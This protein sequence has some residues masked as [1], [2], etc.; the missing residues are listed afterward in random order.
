MENGGFFVYT[1][2][3]YLIAGGDSR[4]ARLASLLAQSARVCAAGFSEYPGD[5]GKA[6]RLCALS[7]L[8]ES[9]DCLILP[10]PASRDG[11]TAAAPFSEETLPLSQLLDLCRRDTLVLAGMAGEG[12]ERLCAK[13]GLT[14]MDYA[15]REELAVLNAVPTAEG[16]LQIALEKLPTVLNGMDVLV[17]GYGRV[18][19]LCRRVFA[20]VGC[21][22]TAAARSR[23]ALAWAEAD[24][25]EPLPLHRM[26]EQLSRFRLVLN[27]VPH[28]LFGKEEL[29]R[30]PPGALLIDLASLPGGT[31]FDAAKELGVQ[32]VHALSLPGKS[33]PE[34]AADILCRTI[35]AIEAERRE[36]D[37]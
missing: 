28:L 13:R 10:M 16:A 19:K 31:D 23:E 11:L 14:L 25:A 29:S 6:E 20:G 12:L 22:V 30:L 34:T 21:K 36:P 7:Q 3:F 5:L 33:A 32:T 4:Y 15:A 17:T 8:K 18:A 37:A 1:Q 2:K 26:P 24:G 9:P 27:T 35:R